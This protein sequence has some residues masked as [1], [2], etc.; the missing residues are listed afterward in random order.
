MKKQ[1]TLHSYFFCADCHAT[2]LN[3]PTGIFIIN[4][5]Q[6]TTGTDVRA[7][8]AALSSEEEQLWFRAVQLDWRRAG[9]VPGSRTT[10]LY[11]PD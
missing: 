3:P 4:T 8:E 10:F 11:D 5:L 1:T 2:D 6:D 7:W 9:F